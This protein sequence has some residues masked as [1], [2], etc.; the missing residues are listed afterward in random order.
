[1]TGKTRKYRISPTY[2]RNFEEIEWYQ[3][4]DDIMERHTTW[5]WG[6][7]VIE[8]PVSDNGFDPDIIAKNENDEWENY[9]WE[10]E[11]TGDGGVEWENHSKFFDEKELEEMEEEDITGELAERGWKRVKFFTVLHGELTVEPIEGA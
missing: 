3:K 7:I 9:E 8:V 6:S 1:M 5:R 4:G 11:E 2:K 10:L